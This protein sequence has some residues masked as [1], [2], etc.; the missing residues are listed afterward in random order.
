MCVCVYEFLARGRMCQFSFFLFDL[1]LR[2]RRQWNINVLSRSQTLLA[3][4]RISV[5]DYC[6]RDEQ[7]SKMPFC[8][9]NPP[10]GNDDIS[11]RALVSDRNLRCGEGRR[12]GAL[13]ALSTSD[14]LPVINTFYLR[15]QESGLNIQMSVEFRFPLLFSF[16]CLLSAT[17][18]TL[19]DF[20]K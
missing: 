7:N 3:R 4:R 13:F 15:R 20:E 12:R 6:R 5:R 18:G 1:C 14:L 8:R 11:T 10:P 17:Q 16:F 19:R 9:C 2:P